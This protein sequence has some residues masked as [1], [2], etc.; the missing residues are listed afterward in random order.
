MKNVSKKFNGSFAIQPAD[1]P[2]NDQ[3]A[4]LVYIGEKIRDTSAELLIEA[5]SFIEKEADL[6]GVPLKIID[7]T[8]KQPIP[9]KVPFE[10]VIVL[11]IVYGVG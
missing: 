5:K 1:V 8:I 7:S 11:E 6:L 4:I 10:Y 9:G 2:T 3:N